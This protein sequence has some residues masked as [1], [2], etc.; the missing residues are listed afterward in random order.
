MVWACGKK[1]VDGLSQWGTGTRKTEVW[2]DGVKVAL[3]NRGMTM[4]AARQ[5]VK[6]RKEWCSDA[7]QKKRVFL[8]KKHFFKNHRPKK[9]FFY[10][11]L[12]LFTI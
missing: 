9:M 8:N 5:C 10:G 11:F 3:C 2:M 1:G 4:E 7:K 12:L 6:D